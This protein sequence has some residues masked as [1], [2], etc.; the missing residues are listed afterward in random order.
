MTMRG[1][2]C[3]GNGSSGVGFRFGFRFGMP[4]RLIGELPRMFRMPSGAPGRVGRRFGWEPVHCPDAAGR[5]NRS[6]EERF[7]QIRVVG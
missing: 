4:E 7:P 3:G 1:P 2:S 5:K 6:S